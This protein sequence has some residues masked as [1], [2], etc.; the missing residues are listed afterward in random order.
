MAATLP[1]YARAR[2][3]CC[4]P[5][6][7]GEQAA[8]PAFGQELVEQDRVSREGMTTPRHELDFIRLLG[9][10]QVQAFAVEGR[11]AAQ[12]AGVAA[13]TLAA[14]SDCEV[15]ALHGYTIHT[16]PA[17]ENDYEILNHALRTG[18]DA[19]RERLASYIETIKA[20]LAKLPDHAGPVSRVTNLPPEV[21]RRLIPGEIYSD[22]AFMS[23]AIGMSNFE[24]KYMFFIESKTGKHIEFFS[25]Y[26]K[27][28]EVLYT[29][30]KEFKIISVTPRSDGRVEILLEEV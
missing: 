23:T 21:V 30:G 20:G 10:E 16:R 22:P 2:C 6:L 15:A 17:G 25:R 28:R 12:A 19:E 1:R 7:A 27:Q 8:L 13:E 18:S 14:L 29:P 26:P 9:P 11:A 4:W 5:L 3:S 24:G